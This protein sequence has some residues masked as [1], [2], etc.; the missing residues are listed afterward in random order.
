M[1]RTPHARLRHKSLS[2]APLLRQAV[3]RAREGACCGREQ[4]AKQRRY[5]YRLSSIV[6]LASALPSCAEEVKRLLLLT[7]PLFRA[8]EGGQAGPAR[9]PAS[10]ASRLLSQEIN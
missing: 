2:A 7:Q 5:R 6:A 8:P 3:C 4:N 9:Q 1:S 10:A